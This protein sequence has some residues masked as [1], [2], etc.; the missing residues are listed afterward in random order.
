[1]DYNLLL[2]VASE[3]GYLL[4]MSGAETFR[5]EDS[6]SRVLRAYGIESEVYS[7]PNCL[8]VS[9]ETPE[10]KPMTRMR[11]VGYHGNNLD[12]VEKYNTLSRYL[13]T[14]TPEPAKAMRWLRDT[15]SK[16]SRYK[17]PVLLAANLLSAFGF[18][19]LFGGS[20]TDAFCAGACGLVVGLINRIMDSLNTNQFVRTIT[21]SFFMAALA[22]GL[23]AF[24]IAD[25]ADAAII[26]SLMLLVPGLLFT[27]AM[28]DIMSGDTNSGINRIMQVFLIAAAICL[29]AGAAWSVLTPVIGEPVNAPAIIH[30]LPIEAFGAFIGSVGFAILFNIHGPG[31]LICA[32]G[33]V[34]TW[35]AYRLGPN[36][37]CSD[38]MSYF[39]ATIVAAGYSEAMARIRKFPVLAYLVVSIFPLIPGAGVYYTMNYAVRGDMVSFADKGT[40]TIAIAAM[41]AVGMLLVSTTVHLWTIW[42]RK[43][44]K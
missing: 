15:H 16:V 5:I 36:L 8:T 10:G 21:A 12:A 14:Y 38:V 23:G 29:G 11:R 31:I 4:S 3:L 25:N 27:N 30:S 13:C 42:Q 33:A 37:G 26:G 28:R 18:C 2:K 40:Q 9:I 44:I 20:L 24:G 32:L 1:M 19:F 17:F 39:W 35:C 43:L 41:M 22:Y 34:L 7:V 6:V